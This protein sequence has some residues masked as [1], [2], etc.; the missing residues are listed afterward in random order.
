[1][2]KLTALI[3]LLCMLVSCASLSA[4]NKDDKTPPNVEVET[5]SDTPKDPLTQQTIV[6]PEY[7]DYG[8]GTVDFNKFVY[9]RADIQYILD[10]FGSLTESVKENGKS[11]DEYIDA[12]RQLEDPLST[13][14]TMYALTE[15]HRSRNSSDEYWASEYE[16]VSTNYP[17]LS[18]AVEDLLVACAKSEHRSYFEN[19]YFGY[20]LEKYAQ[21]GIYTDEVVELM[22]SEA[23]LE[24]QY[25][26]LGTNNVEITYDFSVDKNIKWSGT[27][28]EVIAMAKEYHGSNT[29]NLERSLYM[30][31]FLYEIARMEREKDIYVDLIKVRRLIADELGY[32]SY[33]E[34]AYENMEYDYSADEMTDLIKDIGKYASPVAEEL[35]SVVFKS[36]F[37]T[38]VKPL[39]DRV[40]V[41]NDLY[42]VYSRLGGNYADTYSYMLQHGLYD[43]EYSNSNRYGGAFSTYLDDNSSPYL[44][45]TASGFI[46]DYTTL[47]H[48]FG[49]FLD[50]YLNYGEDDSLAMME[51]SS[52]ALEL[53]TV[54]KLKNV[55]HSS[56]YGYLEYYTLFTF[57]NSV[58]L[59]QSFYS[60][61]EHMVY[62]LSYDEITPAK[63]ES[64]VD[65]AFTLVFGENNT[66]DPDLTTVTIT[67]T[68]LYP[69]Y[70]ESYVSSALVSLDIFFKESSKTGNTGDGFALYESLINRDMKD[71]SFTERLD[72]AGLDSPFKDGKIKE[73]A[74]NIYFLIIGKYY[75]R[76]SENDV[77][78]A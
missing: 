27:V 63:L 30:I 46:G 25:T 20:S 69:F 29:D 2:K 73:T 68:A 9:S 71:L 19:N 12:M 52:Q 78:A 4:P 49:H 39:A 41:I 5:P 50:G 24:A 61:F 1:M 48:E 32:S 55:L 43:V 36:Y 66:F 42:K 74:N 75:Y 10:A 26:S 59:T 77:N 56:E 65:E 54:L 44:F 67:H 16:Y 38:N 53:L 33:S 37:A 7:K 40:E 34:L 76:D 72:E 51:I 31:E 47:A 58:L 15:I 21:G 18:Q 35:E 8:R 60:A 57:L 28:D 22:E 64:I 11:A 23:A 13:V 14:K 17:K 6:V 45:M 3:L 70:V 62:E